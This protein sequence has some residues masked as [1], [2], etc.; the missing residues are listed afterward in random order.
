MWH[1]LR[2]CVARR[3]SGLQTRFKHFW[4]WI[5]EELRSTWR[6]VRACVARRW[7]E[8][9]TRFKHFWECIVEELRH[10][11]MSALFV[12]A[13]VTIA[14]DQLGLFNAIDVF[15][16]L[17]IG[18]RVAGLENA[19]SPPTCS[20][21]SGVC[22]IWIDQKAYETDY[23]ARSP[24]NRCKL[25]DDLQK[26]YQRNPKLLV[27]DL[28]LSPA[29]WLMRLGSAD[30]EHQAECQRALYSLIETSSAQTVLMSPFRVLKDH[31]R[32]RKER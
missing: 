21:S 12:T 10:T 19:V 1:S 29:L 20:T 17:A 4:E 15:A 25:Y 7:S 2:A 31:V 32:K 16:F 3:W 24:L 14:H 13:I 11:C 23:S 30:P 27:I 8:L 26:I 6:S 22:V 5:V 9:Q 28:D 18:N